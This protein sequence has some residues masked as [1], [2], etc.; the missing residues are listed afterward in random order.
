MDVFE[1]EKE[2]KRQ[3]KFLEE[4][5]KQRYVEE[6]EMPL[7]WKSKKSDIEWN[8]NNLKKQL[9]PT[10]DDEEMVN[11]GEIE[12]I[13]KGGKKRRTRK[14]RK[15]GT[16][17]DEQNERNYYEEVDR[18]N[19][20]N[21]ESFDNLEHAMNILVNYN[22]LFTDKEI[23]RHYL[24]NN[25]YGHHN[26]R[27]LSSY[28]KAEWIDIIKKEIGRQLPLNPRGFPHLPPPP[29]PP[30]HSIVTGGKRKSRKHRKSK[31]SRKHKK[32]RKSR[33]HRK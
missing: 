7:K 33:K 28:T 3:M 6:E 14:N 29:L 27:P 16:I 2:L 10:R 32:S 12:K 5:E 21:E 25:W 23:A 8:I 11:F 19:I 17:E 24:L 4:H 30:G 15:G 20:K 1:V 9:E 13:P 18:Q 31:K 22:N 26:M